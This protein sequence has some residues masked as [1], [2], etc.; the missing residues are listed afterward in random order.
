MRRTQ[1]YVYLGGCKHFAFS[2]RTLGISNYIVE[3]FLEWGLK[4]PSRIL[5]ENHICFRVQIFQPGLPWSSSTPVV[6][7]KSH[8]SQEIKK[9]HS[10]MNT[11]L[12]EAKSS[13]LKQWG[14]F[15][16]VGPFWG[17]GLLP[18]AVLISFG[19][20]C[21]VSILRNSYCWWK[22]SCITW[23]GKRYCIS[24]FLSR[25]DVFFFHHFHQKHYPK[26]TWV[27]FFWGVASLFLGSENW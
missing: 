6:S 7:H 9:V 10:P 2:P 25:C 21:F 12:F 1:I 19:E 22:R 3:Y 17:P 13:H 8:E 20:S 11:I 27:F 14:W 16:W 26:N 5:L 24:I 23:D 18:G 15:R 4:P